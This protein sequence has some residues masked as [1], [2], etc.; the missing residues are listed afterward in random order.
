[1]VVEDED[2]VREMAC[3]ALEKRG[4]Q[5]LQAP[6]GPQAIEVWDRSPSAVKLLFTDMVMPFGMTGGQLAKILSAKNPRLQ[7]I[8]TSGYNTEFMQRDSLLAQGIN[9]IPKPYDVRTLSKAIRYCLDGG[10]LPRCTTRHAK[11]ELA[12]AA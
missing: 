4:Y 5:V 8:Y 1:M 2:T 3:V 10:K 11:T 12:P 9:F 7:V 6:N